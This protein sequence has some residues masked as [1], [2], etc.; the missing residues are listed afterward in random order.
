MR[1]QQRPPYALY[2]RYDYGSNQAGT[3]RMQYAWTFSMYSTYPLPEAP[4]DQ[5][6]TPQKPVQCAGH[7]NG[8]PTRPLTPCSSD[9]FQQLVTAETRKIML[10][11][12]FQVFRTPPVTLWGQT[13]TL[14]TAPHLVVRGLN[15][16]LSS[17]T[18]YHYPNFARLKRGQLDNMTERIH[19]ARCAQNENDLRDEVLHTRLDRSGDCITQKEPSNFTTHS[20]NDVINP[21]IGSPSGSW[22]RWRRYRWLIQR[23]TW[24]ARPIHYLA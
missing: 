10:P 16:L 23:R 14:K 21:K 11:A 9:A 1:S 22:W 13:L 7:E 15:K 12:L 6:L 18:D 3:Q 20:H 4:A 17:R 19:Q 8:I 24:R 5:P 2:S